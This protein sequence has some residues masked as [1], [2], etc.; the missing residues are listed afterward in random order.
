[1]DNNTGG[2]TRCALA[3]DLSQPGDPIYPCDAINFV[4][5]PVVSLQGGVVINSGGSGNF[6]LRGSNGTFPQTWDIWIV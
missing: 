5:S 1:M 3:V 4:N 6:G 2:A